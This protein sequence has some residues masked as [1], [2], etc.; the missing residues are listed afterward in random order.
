MKLFGL[1]YFPNPTSHSHSELVSESK[2]KSHTKRFFASAQNDRVHN[3]AAF[4]LAEVL[5]TLGVIGVVAA[6]TLPTLINN[7][8]KKQ[9]ATRLKA[10]YSQLTQAI[11][12]STAENEEVSGWDCDSPN[13]FD[14][15]LLNYMVGIK[16]QWK[17]LSA[18]DSIPYKQISGNRE[19]GLAMLRPGFGG[20]E[21]YT[22]LNGVDIF[23]YSNRKFDT[24]GLKTSFII[25][26]NGT[27]TKPNQFGKD[28]FYFSL[29]EDG[30]LLPMGYKTTNECHVPGDFDRE[31]LKKGTCLNYGCN[32]NGRGMW[33]A[34]LLMKD[35]W[36]I[37]S[38]YPW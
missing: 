9:A 37:L 3:K 15:Y 13:W 21:V 38:D 4:T 27:S 31:F 36:Q 35:G 20:T 10:A 30:S 18:P 19:T 23:F 5:I 17:D 29:W 16:H 8:Q 32:K 26:T 33:C 25:D 7:Y 12:M 1:N 14:R 2:I 22:L 6:L 11:R 28:T 24:K 34:A